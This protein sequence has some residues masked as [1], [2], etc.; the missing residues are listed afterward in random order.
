MELPGSRT[1]KQVLRQWD[2]GDNKVRPG[3]AGFNCLGKEC[4]F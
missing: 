1:V 3:Y 2:C 4:E